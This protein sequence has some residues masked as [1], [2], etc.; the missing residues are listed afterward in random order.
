MK[1]AA[2]NR[3]QAKYDFFVAGAIPRNSISPIIRSRIAP[4]VVLLVR[5]HVARRTIFEIA[6]IDNHTSR[7]RQ[8]A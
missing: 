1:Y 2:N 5:P 7:A 4:I 8:R 6:T 3:Q